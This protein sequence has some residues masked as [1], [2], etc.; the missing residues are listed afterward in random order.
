MGIVRK[1]F[2][3]ICFGFLILPMTLFLLNINIQT[4]LN[5]V[6]IKND[7]PKI[8]FK[9]ILLGNYQSNYD[10]WFSDEVPF[11]SYMIKVYDQIVY[12]LGGEVNEIYRGKNGDLHGLFWLDNYLINKMDSQVLGEYFSNIEYINKELNRRGKKLFYIVTPNKAEV[13]DNTLPLKYRWIQ[14]IKRER[15]ENRKKILEFLKKDEI[16]YLDLTPLIESKEL[17]GEKM[18]PKTGIHWNQLGA[19]YS[20]VEILK[21]MKESG[22]DVQQVVRMNKRECNIPTFNE[23]D[24][25]ELL[26]VYWSKGDGPYPSIE[27]EYSNFL[28]K[29]P[30]VFAM[31]TSF[32]NTIVELFFFEFGMPFERLERLH[33]NQHRSELYYVNGKLKGERRIPG[34]PME[35]INYQEILTSYD[36]LIIE[37]PSTDVPEAHIQFARNFANY[38]KKESNYK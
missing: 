34:I 38:L 31:T 15:A 1:L 17:K 9:E 25:K 18:F 29:R 32:S 2:I 13:H 11:R 24:Y 7:K 16:L 5:G 14:K 33:Y 35:K 30:S 27:L 28:K 21:K 4:K 26:N 22:V 10:K 8:K 23:T 19:A 37:H 3:S 36:I 20:L 12:S 6:I